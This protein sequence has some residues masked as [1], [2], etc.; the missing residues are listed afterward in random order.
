MHAALV[1]ATIAEVEGR[2]SQCESKELTVARAIISGGSD[3][4]DVDMVR[5]ELQRHVDERKTSI[6]VTVDWGREWYDSPVNIFLDSALRCVDV[7]LHES[8][9]PI[10]GTN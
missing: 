4:A 1:S 9:E 8:G 2:L 3:A 5:E 7:V 10:T 6:I